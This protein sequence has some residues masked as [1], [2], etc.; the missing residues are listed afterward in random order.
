MAT[1]PAIEGKP[2]L[3]PAAVSSRMKKQMLTLIVAFQKDVRSEL[4]RLFHVEQ[5]PVAEAEDAA[6]YVKTAYELGLLQPTA[7]A[8]DASLADLAASLVTRLTDKW[9][10]I[11]D[12]A[13]TRI[14]FDMADGALKASDRQLGTSL[15]EVSEGFTLRTTPAVNVMV[16]A[17]AQQAAALIKR[18]PAQYLPDIQ[19]ATMR[20]ITS[21]NG[22]KDLE[23]E[24]AKRNVAVK[25]WVHNVARDQTRK[26]YGTIS[27]MRMQE[28]GV[29]KF[30]WVHSGG[31]NQPR[32]Y[33]LHRWPAGLNGGIFSFD[34]PPIINEKTG[35]RGFPGDEPYCGCTMSP[36]FDLDEDD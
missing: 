26:A 16:D 35:K 29:K 28:A 27:R 20:S 3:I 10:S 11:F 6:V 17:A 12:K 13:A 4:R 36:Y 34:D 18:V 1:K 22:L 15:K 32:E 30:K 14:G 2:L 21:G 7:V 25:N 23:P 19:Q 8:M 31:S 33:H 24:L 5:N 9:Q